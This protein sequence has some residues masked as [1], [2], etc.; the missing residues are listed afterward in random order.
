MRDERAS[1]YE[2]IG[3][4]QHLKFVHVTY[5]PWYSISVLMN[6]HKRTGRALE[7]G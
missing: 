4:S 7:R 3:G 5:R 2:Y 6:M 1:V